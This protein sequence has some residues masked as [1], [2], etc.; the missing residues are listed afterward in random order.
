MKMVFYP[1]VLGWILMGFWVAGLMA[2]SKIVEYKIEE[3]TSD[4]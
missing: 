1:S 2:K 3:D 4:I